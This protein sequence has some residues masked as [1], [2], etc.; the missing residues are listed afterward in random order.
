[1]A[2]SAGSA[3]VGGDDMDAGAPSPYISSTTD[4]PNLTIGL[5]SEGTLDWAH[6][7]LK[8]A[9]DY[10]HKN[11]TNPLLWTLATVGTRPITLYT[12]ASD[13]T[14]VWSDGIPTASATTR[15]GVQVA[16]VGE[17]FVVTAPATAQP[18]LLRL[19]VGVMAGTGQFQAKFSD[20]KAADA[21]LSDV[22][23][24]DNGIWYPQVITVEYAD[25]APGTTISITWKVLS[26]N[27]AGVNP[28][29]SLKA[30][31]LAPKL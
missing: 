16:G 6:W 18:R 29:V 30:V 19:Y 20:P 17:G 13:S 26:G 27:D 7:G 25:A 22:L 14:F 1:V 23:T 9:A 12:G 31:T 21:T 28:A 24:S 2:G 10:N 8:M 5:S 15:N 4:G 11:L 3:G